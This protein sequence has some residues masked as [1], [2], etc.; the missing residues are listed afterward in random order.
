[1]LHGGT[2][3]YVK[4]AYEAQEK[5]YKPNSDKSLLE[6]IVPL[7]DSEQT[8][9]PETYE[10]P[11]LERELWVSATTKISLCCAPYAVAWRF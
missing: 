6:N 7:T 9:V 5:Y 11:F 3:E 8:G 1:V 10:W 4:K 2:S